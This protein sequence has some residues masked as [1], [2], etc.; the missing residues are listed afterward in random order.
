[1][2]RADTILILEGGRTKEYG[3]RQELAANPNSNFA[4]LLR[5]GLEE[6]LV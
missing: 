3:P 2:A 6:I 4:Q 5:T 1:V